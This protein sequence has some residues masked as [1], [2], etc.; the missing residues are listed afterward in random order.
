MQFKRYRL[1]LKAIA[2]PVVSVILNVLINIIIPIFIFM[3]LTNFM[4]QDVVSF[5]RYYLKF[6][7]TIILTI[8]LGIGVVS[9]S[10][11]EYYV[12][13]Y[14]IKRLVFSCLGLI[15][16]GSNIILW[17]FLTDFTLSVGLITLNINL[18]LL[19]R[20]FLIIPTILIVKKLFDFINLR[21]ENLFKVNVLQ[22]IKE[23]DNINSM[24]QIR[25]III[26]DRFMEKR[27]RQ[28]LLKNLENIMSEYE[29][30]SVP[31]IRK[32]PRYFLTKKGWDILNYYEN[33]L[34]KFIQ[35]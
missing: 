31:F 16:V 32:N 34:N 26:K 1:D 7:R 23:Q 3:D 8:I 10:F 25:R 30:S 19:Y 24:S 20:L 28:Y 15:L 18:S 9:C 35:W 4:S 33:Q 13:T 2:V 6:Q 14:S 5:G 22:I 29:T 27:L 21:R 12:K 11:L 17:S